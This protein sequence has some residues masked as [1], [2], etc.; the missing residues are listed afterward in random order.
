MKKFYVKPEI[1]IVALEMDVYMLT[2]SADESL[3]GTSGGDTGS[4]GDEVDANRHRGE[5][6]NLWAE[7]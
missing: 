3:P 2:N 5:W 6:G 1:E 7:D 4:E